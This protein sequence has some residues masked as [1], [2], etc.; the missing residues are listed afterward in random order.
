MHISSSSSCR[1]N[2]FRASGKILRVAVAFSF[3][4]L[5]GSQA[6]AQYGGGGGMGGTGTSGGGTYT[7]PKG[8]YSS[9]TGIGIGAGAAA[10]VGVLFLAMHYHGRVTGCV[11]PGEDG[12]R[13]VED[14][15][16]TSYA[17]TAGDVH[18][19]AGQHVELKGKKTKGDEGAERFTAKKLIKVIG[20]C[21]TS[22]AAGTSDPRGH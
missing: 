4:L 10:G 11:Q 13:L 7:P 22:A 16:N 6:F 14:K 9:S 19:E 12:L 1:A 15:K 3:A 17:L 5:A 18:L 8:G 20:S 21:G 2:K